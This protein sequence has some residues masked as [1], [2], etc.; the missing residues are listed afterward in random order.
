MEETNE[1]ILESIRNDVATVA[2][3]LKMVAGRVI[4]EGIS[5]YPIFIASQE[6]INIG[7]PMFDRDS[8]QLNWFFS[9][10]ILEDFVHKGLITRTKMADFQRT[11]GDPREKACVFVIV[12]EEGQFV[13]VPYL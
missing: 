5:D 6:M 7:K 12:G 1:L 13:F 3:E 8:V 2:K 11:F 4:D 9:A 10:T